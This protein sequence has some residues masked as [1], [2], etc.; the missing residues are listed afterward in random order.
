[1]TATD[2]PTPAARLARLDCQIRIALRLLRGATHREHLVLTAMAAAATAI[3]WPFPG[4][5]HALVAIP[6]V[7][8]LTALI[9]LHEDGLTE[10]RNALTCAGAD[11]AD[12]TVITAIGPIAAAV[13]GSVVGAVAAVAAGH[14]TAVATHAALPLLAGTIATVVLRPKWIGA[15]ALAAATIA[16]AVAALAVVVSDPS[17][18]STALVAAT[19]AGSGA[20]SHA[21]GWGHGSLPAVAAALVLVATQVA[22]RKRQARSRG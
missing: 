16:A 11:P 4:T 10:R 13:A 8:L 1:V 21:A 19:T 15:P 20:G 7:L 17:S 6:G 12:A 22:G 3:A 9:R 18:R 5:V 14:P 2:A